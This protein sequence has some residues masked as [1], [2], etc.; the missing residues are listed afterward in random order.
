MTDRDVPVVGYTD[1]TADY[2]DAAPMP[3]K[4]DGRKGRAVKTKAAI[5][6]ACRFCMASGD[7]RPTTAS[8]AQ[9]AGVS[10][11]TVFEHFPNIYRFH[12]EALDQPTR[13]AIRDM[14]LRDCLPIGQADADR[15]VSAVVFGGV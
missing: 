5:L 15:L 10:V 2:L 8:V 3:A 7:F 12:S 6:K 4:V 14:I 11:R 9:V 13:D 1:A